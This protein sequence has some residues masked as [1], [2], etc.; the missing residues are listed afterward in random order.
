MFKCTVIATSLALMIIPA[1]AQ[2]E[3]NNHAGR[4][5]SEGGQSLTADLTHLS[6]N[7]YSVELSTT[8]PISGERP[9][10]GGGLKGEIAIE[11]DAGTLS[12]PNEGFIASEAESVLN[13]KLCKVNFKFS[14]KYTL[15]I[16]E[17]SGCTFCHGASCS[18]D[19]TLVHEAS[20]I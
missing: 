8:V 1:L 6:G 4:Y 7:R 20:G 11:A 19:G 10:C 5:E 14:D 18:F 9:G 17:G 13:S 12:I 2:N 3:E 16:E 15:Q